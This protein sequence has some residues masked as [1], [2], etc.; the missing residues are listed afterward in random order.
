MLWEIGKNRKYVP[1][2]PTPYIVQKGP[3]AG[4]AELGT[5][6]D[7]TKLEALLQAE[8]DPYVI[9]SLSK[10][11]YKVKNIHTNFMEEP[12]RYCRHY[13]TH[14]FIDLLRFMSNYLMA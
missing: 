13:C 4:L 10:A 3:L 2:A 12:S 5:I 9:S 1:K 11:I 6:V 8:S 7:A 14:R